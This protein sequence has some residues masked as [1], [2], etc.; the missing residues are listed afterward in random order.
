MYSI[1]IFIHDLYTFIPCFSKEFIIQPDKFIEDFD[2]DYV[3]SLHV[4]K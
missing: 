4:R 1:K 3:S 2:P